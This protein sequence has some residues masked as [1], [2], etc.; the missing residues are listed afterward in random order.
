MFCANEE[1]REPYLVYYL[2]TKL[3]NDTSSSKVIVF[4]NAI[5]YV[6]RL[7]SV[8]PLCFP[9]NPS[10]V[11]VVGMHSNMRQKDRLKKLD[12]FSACKG[13]AVMVATDL[14]A[15]GLDL[16][17]VG[18]VVHLQP[19]RTPESLIH[20]SGR[21]ARAGRSGECC[22]I[23]TPKMSM[24]WGKSV[25]LGLNRELSAITAIEPVS[26][27]INQVRLIHKTASGI[28][29]ET[30]KHK[31]DTKNKAWSEKTCNEAEL[32]D[33]DNSVSG[34]GYDSDEVIVGG[35]LPV[36]QTKRVVESRAH[37]STPLDELLKN[38]LPSRHK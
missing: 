31:R 7:A 38:P 36:A 1:D 12:Q 4:V 3:A 9:K 26:M 28:E 21:T 14:A 8:L 13:H 5:S 2:L 29:G 10:P 25:K 30:H 23:I 17:Q 32:W 16:P 19:P 6:Y 20:R 27:D 18:A 11:L 15:R 35:S 37:A 22:M 33:S 34:G 24:Q